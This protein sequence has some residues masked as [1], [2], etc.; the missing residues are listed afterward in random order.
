MTQPTIVQLKYNWSTSRYGYRIEAIIAHNTVGYDSRAYLSR[1]GSLPTGIDRRV[2]IHALGRKDG[3]IYTYVPDERGA[4]HAGSGTMPRGFTQVNPNFVSIGYELEN[5]SDGKNVVDAYTDKQL[6]AFGWWVNS[7]RALYGPLPI[8]RHGDIDPD[9]RKDPVRLSVADLERW[10]VA[11]AEHYGETAEPLTYRVKSNA[12]ATVRQ[13]PARTGANG[14]NVPIAIT[15]P[16]RTLVYVDEVKE[17]Q[18]VNGDPRW[19]HM[20]RYRD[21]YDMGFIHMSALDKLG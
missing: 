12:A 15:L 10:C 19:V 2:S 20:A 11:A 21:Q 18:A 13:E 3:T 9:R 7:K 4:N 5:A 14:Q 1:G 17:G 16:P 6:L 8:L